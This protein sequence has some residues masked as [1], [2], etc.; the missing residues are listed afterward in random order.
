MKQFIKLTDINGKTV[1]L[2]TDKIIMFIGIG[3]AFI[4]VTILLIV[5]YHIVDLYY[6]IA[7]ME[8]DIQEL[9]EE[10]DNYEVFVEVKEIIEGLDY[11]NK[12]G[13][14]Q[15]SI[16]LGDYLN[17]LLQEIKRKKWIWKKLNWHLHQNSR[18]LNTT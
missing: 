15:E 2:N 3:I 4:L 14:F 10:V 8:R 11:V 16:D 13:S 5:V 1:I 12:L 18:E 6:H 17:D 7:N 9:Q